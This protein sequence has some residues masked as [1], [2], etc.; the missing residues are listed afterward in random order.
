MISRKLLIKSLNQNIENE[1]YSPLNS[2]SSD[3][4]FV[5]VSFDLRKL[6]VGWGAPRTTSI[7]YSAKV[8]TFLRHPVVNSYH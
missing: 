3:I 1:S 2:L 4:Q 7:S 5:G 8:C 6:L